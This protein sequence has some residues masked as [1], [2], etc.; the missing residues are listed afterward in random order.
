[1]SRFLERCADRCVEQT[2]FDP[3]RSAESEQ[4]LWNA[5]PDLLGALKATAEHSVSLGQYQ[6]TVSQDDI[7]PI[8][9]ALMIEIDRVV[10]STDRWID[11]PLL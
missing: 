9:R 3:R 6:F 7:A 11:E 8:G 4:Q 1:M 10:A 2:R 5:L